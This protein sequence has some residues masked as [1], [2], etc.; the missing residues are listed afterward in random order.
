MI[1]E[2]LIK[3]FFKEHFSRKQKSTF[4]YMNYS[5]FEKLLPKETDE[6]LKRKYFEYFQLG[7]EQGFTEAL[8]IDEFLYE[9]EKQ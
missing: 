7:F 1:T 6:Q 3:R 2:K 8:T 9:Q 4:H 5:Q